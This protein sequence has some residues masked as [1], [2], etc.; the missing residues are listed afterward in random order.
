MV[1]VKQS[2]HSPE[3][4]TLDLGVWSCLKAGVD[5]RGGK[6]MPRSERFNH[7]MVE[8]AMWRA[9]QE[10]WNEDLTDAKMFNIFCQR[11][12]ISVPTL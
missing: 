9:A 8:A 11:R 12:K 7:E 6:R 2:R 3:T 1:L 5:R 10:S 4:N